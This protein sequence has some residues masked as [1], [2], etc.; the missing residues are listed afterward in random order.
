MW[1]LRRGRLV[2]P[3]SCAIQT[4]FCESVTKYLKLPKA[5]N[6]KFTASTRQFRDSAVCMLVGRTE[7]GNVFFIDDK[8]NKQRL[9]PVVAGSM[10]DDLGIANNGKAVRVWIVVDQ[11]N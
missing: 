1:Q 11:C 5:N 10:M 9:L 8:R 6:I 4:A 3:A 7:S 2:I